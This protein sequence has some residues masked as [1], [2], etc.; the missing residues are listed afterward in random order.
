MT[1]SVLRGYS[2][3]KVCLRFWVGLRTGRMRSLMLTVDFCVIDAVILKSDPA[4]SEDPW[5]LFPLSE[6][7]ACLANLICL[8]FSKCSI[9]CFRLDQDKKNSVRNCFLSLRT[10]LFHFKR[11]FCIF[12]LN[13]F[14]LC[15]ENFS[16]TGEQN[17]IMFYTV[18]QWES[19]LSKRSSSTCWPK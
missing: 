16:S 6:F 14:T 7:P 11:A 12:N 19:Y 4:A 3:S 2:N 15:Q 8:F 9:D 13:Y 1:T 17:S 10:I 18:R 5:S